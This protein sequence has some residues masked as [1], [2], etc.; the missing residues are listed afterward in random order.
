M[1]ALTA[2]GNEWRSRVDTDQPGNQSNSR[3]IDRILLKVQNENIPCWRW[4]G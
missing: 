1:K 3:L 4:L 2:Y